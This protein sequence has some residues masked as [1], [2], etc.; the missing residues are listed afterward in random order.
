MKLDARPFLEFLRSQDKEVLS[1]N[2]RRRYDEFLSKGPAWVDLHIADVWF[3]KFD[4][5]DLFRLYY[6]D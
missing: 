2:E 4:R 3:T 6:G 5:N 1:D